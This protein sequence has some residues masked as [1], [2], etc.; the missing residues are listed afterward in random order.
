[1]SA[2][3]VILIGGWAH[4]TDDL[5]PLTRPLLEQGPIEILAPHAIPDQASSTALT[6]QHL[7]QRLGNHASCILAGWSLGGMLAMQTARAVPERIA[8]LVLISSTPRFC[9]GPDWPHGQASSRVRAMRRRLPSHPLE[10]LVPFHQ[11]CAAPVAADPADL[12]TRC[13]ALT[14]QD[15]ALLQ[16]G[17]DYLLATD[18]R[19]QLEGLALPVEILHGVHDQVI[20]VEAGQTLA[21]HIPGAAWHPLG[22]VGHALPMRRPCPVVDAI[23]RIRERVA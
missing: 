22:G 5:A 23:Q 16:S 1:M 13:A 6:S 20:P 7:V 10:V 4:T 17:L 8:G 3:P 18:L 2:L 19:E 11:L 14:N 12:A 15:P 21:D 9:S